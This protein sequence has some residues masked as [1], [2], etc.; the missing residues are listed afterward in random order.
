MSTGD[1]RLAGELVRAFAEFG[2]AFFQWMQARSANSGLSFG[3]VRLISE[4]GK[5]GPKIMNELSELLGV[6]PRNITALVDGLEA[7]GLL[8]RRPHATDRRAT[9]IELTER[10]STVAA[11]LRATHE[12]E[13][14]E[15][16]RALSPADQ[17]EL[18]R[19]IR[20]VHDE[21]RRGAQPGT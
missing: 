16:F 21:L 1:P 7:D 20:L 4:L 9:V 19:L 3:R 18:L 11:E 5:H 17:A 15:L 13:M 14:T 8:A 10:G 6:T 2:P 12:A